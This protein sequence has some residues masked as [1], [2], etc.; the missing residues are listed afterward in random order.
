[1]TSQTSMTLSLTAYPWP[2]VSAR[3]E[4]FARITVNVAKRNRHLAQGCFPM[5]D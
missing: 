4:G 5:T 1:M 3:A 2:M